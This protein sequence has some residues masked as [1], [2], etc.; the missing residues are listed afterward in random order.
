MYDLP[1]TEINNAMARGYSAEALERARKILVQLYYEAQFAWFCG[2]EENAGSSIE[3][4]G[5][6][7][8]RWYNWQAVAYVEELM[9]R[10]GAVVLEMDDDKN[11]E[12]FL[13]LSHVEFVHLWKASRH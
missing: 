13:D 7:D 12:V 8:G 4:E 10:D 5:F 1:Q 11:S 2:D 3:E 6:I 9:G